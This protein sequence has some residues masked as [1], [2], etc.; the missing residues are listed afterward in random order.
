MKTNELKKKT[1]V[2][3]G[4]VLWDVFPTQ[5]KPGGAP[6]NVAYHLHKFG[7]DSRMISRVGNDAAGEK[8]LSLLTD[9]NIPTEN[10][11]LD[12]TYQTGKVIATVLPGNEMSYSIQ[13]PVAWDFISLDADTEQLVSEA[14]AF[15]FGSLV[16]RS[17][18]S[19]DTLYHLIEKA[20]FNVFDINLRQP[21]YSPE[22]V[23][24]L[25]QKCNLLKLNEAELELIITWF[26]QEKFSEE[27]SVRFLQDEFNIDEVIVTKGSDGASFYTKYKSYTLPAFEVKVKDTCGS[28]DSF[29]AAFL[30]KKFKNETP[31]TGMI[32]ATGLGAFVASQEGACPPYEL[33]QLESFISCQQVQTI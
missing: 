4:E 6:M 29:L 24:Y 2:C 16:T 14:D 18:T 7:V 13:A 22:I 28:G 11:Q 25:L 15:V 10:C 12:N 9:W 1:V 31:E 21:F 32:Y 23:E 27:T 8:L 5:T 33:S 20:K 30:A 26:T 3:Y 19:R 17:T